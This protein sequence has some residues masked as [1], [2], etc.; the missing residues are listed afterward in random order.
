MSPPT[1]PPVGCS[2]ASAVPSG[3]MITN[4]PA[5]TVPADLQPAAQANTQATLQEIRARRPNSTIPWRDGLGQR[6]RVVDGPA[7]A[8]IVSDAAATGAATH[9]TAID[10][11]VGPAGGVTPESKGANDFSHMGTWTPKSDG[12]VRGHRCRDDD[13]RSLTV[14]IGLKHGC[15]EG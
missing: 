8:T 3:V 14:S 12:L 10:R 9:G 11:D 1:H 13:R 15:D 5:V 7:D 2:G 4:P 6:G